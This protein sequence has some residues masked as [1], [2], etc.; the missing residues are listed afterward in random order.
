MKR[1]RISTRIFPVGITPKEI[2]PTVTANGDDQLFA[3]VVTATPNEVLDKIVLPEEEILKIQLREDGN[4]PEACFIQEALT[5]VA[6]RKTDLETREATGAEAQEKE[7]EAQADDIDSPGE[8]ISREQATCVVSPEV[9]SSA[10]IPSEGN[11]ISSVINSQPLFLRSSW[12]RSSTRPLS[13][14][15]LP[16]KASTKKLPREKHHP[17]RTS[18]V[19]T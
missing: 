18:V 5:L 7:F 14:K 1:E 17:R 9:S 15:Q 19:V 11:E 6:E 3:K 13:T 16:N 12:R 10:K 2:Y 8:E 4:E